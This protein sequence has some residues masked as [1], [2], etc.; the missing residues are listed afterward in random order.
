MPSDRR[1]EMTVKRK[2]KRKRE[3][4]MQWVRHV[5]RALLLPSEFW[6]EHRHSYRI[7]PYVTMTTVI[8]KVI[9]IKD[10]TIPY[11]LLTVISSHDRLAKAILTHATFGSTSLQNV[12][13]NNN[14]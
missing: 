7:K 2:E 9:V 5:C 1:R 13:L 12:N 11:T 8:T 10:N 3:S 4:T 14:K 6:A